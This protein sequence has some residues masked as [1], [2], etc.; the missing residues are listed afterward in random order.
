MAML[1]NQMVSINELW[2][3]TDFLRETESMMVL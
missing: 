1:N 2:M 3:G